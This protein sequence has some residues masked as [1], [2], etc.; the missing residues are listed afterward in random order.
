MEEI[1]QEML[2]NLI[3]NTRDMAFGC[4]D[5]LR[6]S[7][8]YMRQWTWQKLAQIKACHLIGTKRLSK[9]IQEYC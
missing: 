2:K 9:P 4:I 6:P 5:L 1:S 3:G 7:D 8:S